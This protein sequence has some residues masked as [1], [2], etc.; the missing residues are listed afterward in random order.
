M[1]AP[2]VVVVGGGLAG[3]TSAL[4]L[5]DAGRRVTLVESRPRLGGRAFSFARQ[6]AGADVTVD[7]GQHVFLRCCDAYRGLL[8][9]LGATERTFLQPRL[10]IPVLRPDG[11]S[12][13]LSR[14][15]GVPAPAHLTAALARYRLLSPLDR[16]RAARAAVAL[17]L[18][19]PADPRLDT[20]TLGDFLR[21]HGQ[22]PAVV[23]ALWG[24]LATA[25]L[26]LHPDHASLALAAKVF[27]TGVL[28]HAAAGDVGHATVPLGD[29]HHG[30]AERSLRD[31]GVDVRLAH[32]VES[33]APDGEVRAR[34]R[35]AAS[36]D[37]VVLR[38]TRTVLAVPP[39]VAFRLLPA[40]ADSDAG[41][42]ARLT[43]SAIVNVHVVYDRRVTDLAFAAGVG[44][45]V[46]WF[47]D[48]TES[49]G[50]ARQ[51]PGAQYLAVTVSAADDVVDLPTTVLRKRFTEALAALLPAAAPATVLDSFVTRERHATFRQAAGTAALRPGPDPG[52][53]AV[54][55]A[56]AW[57]DTGW[58]DTMESAVRSG[59][60]AAAA[61]LAGDRDAA[62][63]GTALR[64]LRE[65]S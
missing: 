15:P 27:R 54:L 39:R 22:P 7:N 12:A 46:Q 44:T 24:V 64:D 30:A 18:L 59:E 23:D 42:A 14:L 38:P 1:T 10:D 43:T 16:A 53:G 36:D 21:R 61:A 34:H 58:P 11:R 47:F 35:T 6:V 31:A 19:D 55:L 41:A 37:E 8:E 56:G 2:D 13:R 48:R 28:D 4:R 60:V 62:R 5:A 32:H 45:P 50:L 63:P 9:R 17:R 49:S 3:I 65:P 52:L 33:V 29:L 51:R 20:Q 25:T 57:T 26:N 40:L